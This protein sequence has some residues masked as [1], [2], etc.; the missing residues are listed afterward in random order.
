[1]DYNVLFKPIT[2]DSLPDYSLQGKKRENVE[3]SI[4]SR[5]FIC[6]YVFKKN[7]VFSRV[8]EYEKVIIV[9][10]V[11]IIKRIMNK[12]SLI[13]IGNIICN[14]IKFNKNYCFFF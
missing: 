6:F 4:F 12:T 13:I 14:F 10:I 11:S 1:M 7:V 3:I 2:V 5:F 8:L 9:G